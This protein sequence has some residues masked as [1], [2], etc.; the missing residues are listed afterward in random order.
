MTYTIPHGIK[1]A[2]AK[3]GDRIVETDLREYHDYTTGKTFPQWGV[4]CGTADVDGSGRFE[5]RVSREKG[6]TLYKTSRGAKKAADAWLARDKKKNPAWLAKLGNR[7]HDALSRFVV[8]RWYQ[9]RDRGYLRENLTFSTKALAL[10]EA[11]KS[12]RDYAKEGTPIYALIRRT[13]DDTV[14]WT[15]KPGANPR[16]KKKNPRDTRPLTQYGKLYA[17]RARRA[18][19]QPA[20][21][22]WEMAGEPRWQH[23]FSSRTSHKMGVQYPR[24]G[25]IPNPAA[26]W[27]K[28]KGYGG[29]EQLTLV[30]PNGDW[31]TVFGGTDPK[32]FKWRT[33][34][35]KGVK[36][37]STVT[38]GYYDTVREAKQAGK[39]ALG[40]KRNPATQARAHRIDTD[41]EF[42]ARTG[43]RG[44]VEK[45]RLRIQKANDH[46]YYIDHRGWYSQ[47]RDSHSVELWG[48]GRARMAK[49]TRHRSYVSPVVAATL[50][51]FVKGTGRLP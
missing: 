48:T 39:K 4:T 31:V 24:R 1:P 32:S 28:T 46:G 15:S 11:K 29:D 2:N 13:S 33:G 34:V 8:V 44:E 49:G 21:V 25:M 3:R 6:Y 45:A 12:I 23:P 20:K 16:D 19:G 18:D 26:P 51:A 42:D 40:Q 17:Y 41:K 30:A 50:N 22:A 14:V 10:E 7:V 47:G 5:F 35:M 27:K 43:K 9:D 38:I 36:G 37:G